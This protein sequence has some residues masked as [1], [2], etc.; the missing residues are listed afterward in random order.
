[1]AIAGQDDHL[2][3]AVDTNN[4]YNEE[5]VTDL[6]VASIRVL[7]PIHL[8]GS[9]DASRK[10]ICIGHTQLMSPQGPLPIQ[11]MLKADNLKDAIDEFPEALKKA[12][13][14]MVERVQQ[15]QDQMKKK[16]DSRIIVPGAR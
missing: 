8:D 7:R 5:S 12:T 2:D 10:V 15:Y 13:L 1:M 3:F 11:A 4:L 16:D 9:P 14:E 6:K